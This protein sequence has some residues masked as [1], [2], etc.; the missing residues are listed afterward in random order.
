M[1]RT[2]ILL[3]VGAAVLRGIVALYFPTSLEVVQV[4][5]FLVLCGYLLWRGKA[6]L[7]SLVVVLA[8]VGGSVGASYAYSVWQSSQTQGVVYVMRLSGDVTGGK[9]RILR[10]AIAGSDSSLARGFYRI[11]DGKADPRKQLAELFDRAQAESGIVWGNTQLVRYS[12]APKPTRSLKS[13]AQPFSSTPKIL[14][15]AVGELHLVTEVPVIGMSFEPVVATGVF[16]RII[17]AANRARGETRE[18]LLKFA[19]LMGDRWRASEHKAYPF[20]LNGTDL[21]RVFLE[22]GGREDGLLVCAV[23]DFQSALTF[24]KKGGTPQ[25]LAA[26]RNNLAIAQVLLLEANGDKLKSAR[27]N[28]DLAK[29]LGSRPD[30]FKLG[31]Q[32]SSVAADNLRTLY[33][34]KKRGM[35]TGVKKKSSGKKTKP[36]R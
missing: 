23:R 16:L 13:I 6:I 24:L 33:G 3:L 29:R 19:G 4:G 8:I 21:I 25:L 17:T 12:P 30:P 36:K 2:L 11:I 18:Q 20:F 15:A 27:K 10:E 32:V 26:V 7:P 22:G 1:N 31:G 9:S 34:M 14:S 28:F 5:V 35:R